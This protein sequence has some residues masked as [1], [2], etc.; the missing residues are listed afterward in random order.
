MYIC[1]SATKE[2]GIL[3]FAITWVK[4][5]DIILR[6]KKNNQGKTKTTWHHLPVESKK[7]QFHRNRE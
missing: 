6:E 7:G 3:P 5:E 4:L 1:D 2:K